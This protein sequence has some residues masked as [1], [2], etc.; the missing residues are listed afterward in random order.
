MKEYDEFDCI[1]VT[2]VFDGR[3]NKKYDEIFDQC[4]S[5]KK[6]CLVFGDF[7]GIHFKVDCREIES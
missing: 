5:D 2:Y 1:Q 4:M 6:A 7:G 3:D